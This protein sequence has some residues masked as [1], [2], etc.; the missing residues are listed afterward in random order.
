MY[1][2]GCD[3][4]G[5]NADYIKE[6]SLRLQHLYSAVFADHQNAAGIFAK[7]VIHCLFIFCDSILLNKCLNGSGKTAAMDTADAAV[8]ENCLADGECQRYILCLDILTGVNVLQI[9]EGRISGCGNGLKECRDIFRLMQ[10]LPDGHVHSRRRN[11]WREGHFGRRW[12]CALPEA[13]RIHLQGH[14][15]AL[16]YPNT[17]PLI[18]FRQ[19]CRIIEVRS[20]WE[21]LV[22]VMHR[23]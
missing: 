13:G 21:P 1:C 23:L 20:A 3:N 17:Q 19:N 7:Q 10:R 9:F 6:K 4:D 16:L 15:G 5:E 14:P 2:D 8:F 18:S 22:S 11:E 12:L